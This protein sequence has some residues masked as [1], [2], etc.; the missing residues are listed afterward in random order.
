MVRSGRLYECRHAKA[1]RCRVA[2]KIVF[3][4]MQRKTKVLLSDVVF[5]PDGVPRVRVCLR[6]PSSD[7]DTAS[8]TDGL[9]GLDLTEAHSCHH[10]SLEDI[11]N[12]SGLSGERQCEYP[13]VIHRRSQ[14]PSSSSSSSSSSATYHSCETQDT[15]QER[16]ARLG[17]FVKALHLRALAMSREVS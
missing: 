9:D 6:P 4:L 11:S 10:C 12:D 17:E 16:V 13:V 3:L 15:L 7:T 8:T 1:F 14:P 2:G 5:T